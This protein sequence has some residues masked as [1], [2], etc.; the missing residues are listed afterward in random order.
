[1]AQ[2]LPGAAVVV[3]DAPAAGGED[4]G[5][6]RLHMAVGHKEGELVHRLSSPTR[7]RYGT[8]ASRRR[9]R[10]TLPDAMSSARRGIH[11]PGAAS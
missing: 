11:A 2:H 10:S 8:C 7:E 3:A 1:M 9:L 5:L 6:H 4:G